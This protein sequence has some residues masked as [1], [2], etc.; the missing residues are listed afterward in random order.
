SILS[1]SQNKPETFPVDVR[2]IDGRA[3]WMLGFAV[4]VTLTLGIVSFTIPWFNR[5]PQGAYWFD[6]RQWVLAIAALVL[7]F[8][9]YAFYQHVQ[10]QRI[11]HQLSERDQLFQLVSENAADMIA[12][13]DSDG[14]RLYNSP[15]YQ[16]VLG[17][18]PEELR[19]TS[20]I[21]QIHPDDRPRVL[22][23][24]EKA[25]LSGQG[26]RVEY[27]MRHKDG[28]WRI[29]ESTACTTRDARGQTDKLVIVNRDITQRKRTEE[30]LLHNAALR[31]AEE[32]YRAIFEDAVVGIF[33]MTPE[34]R[35][36]SINR[37]LAQIHGYESP[38]QLMAEV[39]NLVSQLFVGSGQIDELKRVLD[40]K[41]VVRSAEVE[42]HCRDR[43]RKWVLANVRAVCDSGGKIVLYEGT[44]EDITDRKVAE[45]Q[46]QF[47]AY[48]DALTEL[49]NR[50]L[51]RDRL[52]KALAGSRR[53]KDK[54]AVLFL[55]LDRFKVINDSLGHSFGDLL[56]RKIADRLKS[57]VREQDT[58]ARVGGDEFLVVLT[59]VKDGTDA[60]I[61]AEKIMDAMIAELV[62]Q[63][64]SFSVSCSMG[65]SIFP[66]HG[67]DSET[68]IKNADAAMY[69]AKESGRNTFQFFSEKMNAEVVERLTLE[70][71][72]RAA[73]DKKEFFLVYQ[74]QMDMAT[75]TIVGF[76]ALLRWQH[77]E[78][79][80][81]APDRFMGI[82]ENS[83]LILPI[84]AWV[85]R[86]ACS[87]ARKWQDEGL[88][89]TPVAVNVSA[90]QFRQPG[91]REVVSRVLSE[92]GLACQ[93]LELEVTESLLLSNADMT[94]SVLRELKGMGLKLAI[95]DFGTGYSS[96]SYLKQFPFSKLKID[97][98][99][100]RDVAVNSDDAAITTAIISMAKSLSLKVI[101]EG[102]ENEA[103]MSFLRKLGC[104]EIQGYYFSKPLTAEEISAR[105]KLGSLGNPVV[106][107]VSEID[108]RTMS[109]RSSE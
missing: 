86:T 14:R 25:R 46:V 89:A 29:L 71:G 107:L 60:A 6:Q 21:E 92:T 37:A 108:S 75:G 17:Y 100:I 18:S 1:V 95:D 35:P 2:Q 74:P 79:G 67:A 50:T 93:Y 56:L 70:H 59:D 82:A 52:G 33:Q 72:L 9:L 27:R 106:R 53:R 31:H 10:L 38:E 102:V 13:V 85:L 81:I 30:L 61:A 36:L 24:A 64:R 77:P 47:L 58:V 48:Y 19:A 105:L 90:V 40:E 11:R 12:V 76:E 49:P 32:K 109:A 99:F 80:T 98:S 91:F 78:L 3:W 103:Q 54:V 44:L 101:A 43:S 7:F 4:S 73:L 97:R 83:G 16:K 39:S 45:N 69:S 42:V 68:L 88:C 15:A 8:D 87:Q 94:S 62:I 26:E 22:R 96:L 28:S 51:L 104:E 5:A 20:S 55:D 66:E 84:G 65:I 41:G 63:G 34:G 23:A 57:Q